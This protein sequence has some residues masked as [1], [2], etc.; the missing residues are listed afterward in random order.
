MNYNNVVILFHGRKCSFCFK[1]KIIKC[2]LCKKSSWYGYCRNFQK[3]NLQISIYLNQMLKDTS[4][5]AKAV[6]YNWKTLK[7]IFFKL[8]FEK[9]TLSKIVFT[10]VKC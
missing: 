4:N 5:Y 1:I 2:Y 3:Y 8:F 6:T 7:I 10:N 9:T